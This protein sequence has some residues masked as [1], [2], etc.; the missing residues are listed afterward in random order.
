M[1]GLS[2]ASTIGLEV[3][4]GDLGEAMIG[5]ERAGGWQVDRQRQRMSEEI[6]SWRPEIKG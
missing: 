2:V 5:H 3:V 4:G 1:E 6:R